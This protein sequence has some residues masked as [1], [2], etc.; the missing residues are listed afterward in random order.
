MLAQS[1]LEIKAVPV[2]LELV[3]A[4]ELYTFEPVYIEP[5]Y[6]KLLCVPNSPKIP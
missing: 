5:G 3:H 2:N 4:F 6:L 1:F